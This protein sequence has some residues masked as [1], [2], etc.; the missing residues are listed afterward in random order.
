MTVWAA[1][2][3]TGLFS[4]AD[5]TTIFNIVHGVVSLMAAVC[6]LCSA[7]YAQPARC[8]YQ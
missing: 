6:T 4:F 1:V 5:S 2:H 3:M 8:Q 7:A